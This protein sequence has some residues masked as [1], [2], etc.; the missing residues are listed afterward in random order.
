[1]QELSRNIIVK[2]RLSDIFVQNKPKN[3]E[4]MKNIFEDSLKILF[5]DSFK[6]DS[7]LQDKLKA[8]NIDLQAGAHDCLVKWSDIIDDILQKQG[9]H[10]NSD[11]NLNNWSWCIIN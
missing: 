4:D 2:E 8:E 9:F 3:F 5:I 7:I 1:M 10:S 11:K 6:N